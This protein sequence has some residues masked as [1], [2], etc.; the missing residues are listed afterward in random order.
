LK[1]DPQSQYEV[2]PKG[3]VNKEFRKFFFFSLADFR[4]GREET[5]GRREK[6][7]ERKPMKK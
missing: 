6:P 3:R 7:K 1:I 2:C 5:L 4:I